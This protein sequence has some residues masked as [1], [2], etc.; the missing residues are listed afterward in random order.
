MKISDNLQ[1]NIKIIKERLPLDKS[2]DV[3]GRELNFGCTQ[4]YLVFIDG[5]VKDDIM[6]WLLEKLQSLPDK[7]TK[8]NNLEKWIQSHIGYVETETIS[9]FDQLE[10]S[11]LSGAVV[12]LLEDQTEAILIDARTYPARGPEEPELEKVTRGSKDGLVETIIFN[13]A[14]I[15]R[16]LRDPKLIFEMTH[17]GTRSKTDIAIGYIDD[18]VEKKLLYQVKKKLENIEVDS[19][20]M[21]EKSLEELLIK[22]KWYDPLPQAKFT[23]RPDVVAAHLNEGHIAI[24]VDTSPSVMLLPVTFFHF[25]QHSEDY[26][27]NPLIGTYIRWIRFLAIFC[28]LILTPLWLQLVEHKDLLPEALQFIGPKEEVMIPLFAQFILLEIGLDIIRLA[29]IHTPSSLSNS[30]A[31]IGGLILSQFAVDVGWFVPET[32]LYMA[33]VGISTFAT[34]SIEFSQAIR[35]FRMFLLIFSGLFNTI[36]FVIALII[37]LIIIFTTKTF[38]GIRYTWPLIPFNKEALAN[39]LLRKPIIEIKRNNKKKEN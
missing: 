18:L 31:I 22:K 9:D 34:P 4:G 19:L 28:S 2:F 1:D 25:T 27:Q 30:L 39:V 20:V 16:R 10:F 11:V 21:G 38:S 29:S 13:T 35:I 33:I 14:L 6:L 23:E 37:I 7:K 15:R 24:L 26:Y 3:I 36:G 17:V 8:V 12:L 32:I 5:F